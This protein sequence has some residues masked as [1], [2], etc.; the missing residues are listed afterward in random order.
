MSLNSKKRRTSSIF[1]KVARIGFKA[2]SIAIIIGSSGV[3]PAGAVDPS[4]AAKGVLGTESGKEA[5]NQALKLSRTKPALTLATAITC[6]ACAP[7]AGVG[8]SASM[9][10]ACG[11][12]IAKTFG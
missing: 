2:A 11:I 12:L 4:E 7:A 10:I 8:A 1:K 9:C 5:L 3:A 6:L